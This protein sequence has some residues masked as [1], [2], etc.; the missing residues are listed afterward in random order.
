MEN[1]KNELQSRR[2]FFKKSL[3]KALPILGAIAM[4]AIPFQKTNAAVN[5]CYCYGCVGGCQDGCMSTCLGECYTGCYTSC[6]VTCKG[7]CIGTCSGT[8][9][10]SCS[11][12]SYF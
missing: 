3:Q 10:G 4:L 5:E 1:K 11:G 12:S 9:S 2:D 7:T 8:C 6:N